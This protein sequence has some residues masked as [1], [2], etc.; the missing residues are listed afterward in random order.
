M[1][2]LV[3]GNGFDL[4]HELPTKYKDFL[5]F[6]YGFNIIVDGRYIP[7]GIKEFERVV[8]NGERSYESSGNGK[9]GKKREFNKYVKQMLL[10]ETLFTVEGLNKWKEEKHVSELKDCCRGNVWIEYFGKENKDQQ[11]TWI[12]F[13]TEISKVIKSLDYMQKIRMKR[14]ENK[15]LYCDEE[16]MD[17]EEKINGIFNTKKLYGE[18]GDKIT[19]DIVNRN[20]NDG[21]II[22][23]LLD[24][25]NK[26]IRCLEIYLNIYVGDI[27][28]DCISPD[29]KNLAIDKVISFNYTNTYRKIYEAGSNSIDYHFIHGQADYINNADI[30]MNNMVLGIDE[31]LNS[32]LMN[33]ETDF[34]GFKKYFQRIYKRTGYKYKKWINDMNKENEVNNIYF[35]GHSL[36][37]TDN[38]VLK[39]LIM[40]NSSCKES[41]YKNTNITIFH[42]NED[43]LKSQIAN[44][45][46]VIGKNEL[47]M[48]VSSEKNNIVFKKQKGKVNIEFINKIKD[49][50]KGMDDK[51]KN[52][53]FRYNYNKNTIIIGPYQ[54]IDIKILENNKIEA[55]LHYG[56]T[57]AYLGLEEI[58]G[59]TIKSVDDRS[60]LYTYN[61]EL[62][63]KVWYIKKEY[64]SYENIEVNGEERIEKQNFEEILKYIKNDN[65]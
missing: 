52:G 50:C 63:K 58:Y 45:V 37:I 46:K 26:L 2:I 16:Y 25:L 65:K 51:Y 38:D 23:I 33:K 30:K 57:E 35:F 29:I 53:L 56:K 48:R 12:D 8:I 64:E 14:K 43:S 40:G 1:N 15:D 9:I 17:I 27:K 18:I 44:L 39:E 13:E 42:Y 19:K 36:D 3:I 49:E 11:G 22:R 62:G 28:I 10:K 7:H 24:D 21:L 34:I 41:V 60:V 59:Q 32:D 20:L 4:E 61:I 54:Y 55:D 5:D 6:L 31:Y 47:I